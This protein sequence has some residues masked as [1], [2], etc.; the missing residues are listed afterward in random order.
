MGTGFVV[1]AGYVVTN[2]HVVDSAIACGNQVYG[3]DYTGHDHK[4]KVVGLP[5]QQGL[6][7]DIAILSSQEGVLPLPALALADSEA[8]ISG[9]MGAKVFTLGYGTIDGSRIPE[10]PAMSGIGS[11]SQFDSTNNMFVTENISMK[12]GNSGG[13]L[14]LE[15]DRRVLGLV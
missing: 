5:T 8:F 15:T 12:P 11:L 1:K 10:S 13:P 4:L 9:H 6:V 14:L 3:R 7:N 2:A